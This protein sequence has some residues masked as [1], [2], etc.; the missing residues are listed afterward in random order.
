MLGIAGQ[1]LESASSPFCPQSEPKLTMLQVFSLHLR[2]AALMACCFM[3]SQAMAQQSSSIVF[4]DDAGVLRYR[5]DAISNHITDFSHAGYKNGEA[6]LPDVPVVMTI[7]PVAG[8]NT[9][10]IQNALNEVAARTPAANGYRGT[11]LLEAGRY[12]VSGQLF[13]RESGMVLRG[14][15]QETSSDL[16]T[17][18][19]GVGN[20]P[21]LRDLIVVG[22]GS[23]AN[24]TDQIPG[25][26][27]DIT[28]PYLPAGSRTLEVAAAEFYR[29]GDNVIITHP[30]TTPWLSTINFGATVSDEDWAPGEIDILYNRY[31]TDVNIPESK[32]TLDAPIY[33]HLERSLSQSFI[34]I[35]NSPGLRREIGVENL[36]I[37]IAS[38][39]PFDEE[40]ARTAIFLEGVEDCWV[41]DVTALH[42]SFAMVDMETAS[43]VTV[44]GCSGLAPHS[45]ITGAR[46][47]NFNVSRRSNNILFRDCNATE[48][49]HSF[50]SNGTSS[51][52]GIVWTN[53]TSDFDYSTSEGHRRWSQGLLFDNI[54]FRESNTSNLIGL[55][56]RG[57]AGTGHGWSSVHSVAWS[58]RTPLGRNVVVQRP[59]LRQN[60][61]IGCISNV[62]GDGP[63]SQPAGFIELAN[64]DLAIPSL[65]A[66]QL[67][68]RMANGAQPDAPARLTGN[69]ADG[70][71]TLA[72]LEIASRETGYVV[73][74][75]RDGGAT[76]T[77]LAELPADTDRYVD[78]NPGPSSEILVYRVF[79]VRDGLPSPYSN[80]VEVEGTNA[81]REAS[82]EELTISPNP[83]TD[84]LRLQ[85]VDRIEEV[86]VYSSTGALVTTQ[87][88]SNQLHTANWP[89]G[90]YYLTVRFQDGTVRSARVVKN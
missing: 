34:Y 38:S 12:E 33:D 35:L 13:V 70:N 45:L 76:F 57:D 55:Y 68:Q 72:W 77:Q 47:Y 73:E 60:Y 54:D 41:K 30:S 43:R 22:S 4:K 56:S 5:T 46:R 52:S 58:V 16:N 63:F 48:G 84:L 31:I 21:A 89:T 59:P 29:T 39:G 19:V 88:G 23:T 83:V 80:E 90:M 82:S 10:H 1:K 65:Y 25:T 69:L 61:A 67:A 15:G 11:L 79:C 86:R 2:S 6:E 64:Q 28:S 78:E 66:E 9:E 18:I 32:I 27:A 44:Q 81:I 36:R 49:R 20:V 71:V 53:C 62:S 51:V 40:H 3:V 37:E 42:F 75:S 17:V 74:I 87:T 8:D 85:S 50:V 26:R 24:W 14:S 7:G